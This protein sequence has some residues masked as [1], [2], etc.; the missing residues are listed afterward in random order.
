MTTTPDKPRRQRI[1]KRKEEIAL[2]DASSSNKA[3]RVRQRAGRWM[4]QGAL[5][6][7]LAFENQRNR[8]DVS[9]M[10]NTVR[11]NLHH[12]RNRPRSIGNAAR[13][14]EQ[15]LRE[16]AAKYSDRSV[17]RLSQKDE[18]AQALELKIVSLLD[19]DDRML[20]TYILNR[21][22]KNWTQLTLVACATG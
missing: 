19:G 1:A 4:V 12:N 6:W 7:R 17:R 15:F 11:A 20:A 2:A 21:D 13:I 9:G 3:S 22:R 5:E 10:G 14:G 16:Q 18:G 8:G